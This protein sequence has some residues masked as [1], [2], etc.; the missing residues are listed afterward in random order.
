M[1]TLTER[2]I[3]DFPR[4]I[5]FSVSSFSYI[6]GLKGNGVLYQVRNELRP[7]TRQYILL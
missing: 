1:R 6:V 2:E 4:F 3:G 5:S 7:H